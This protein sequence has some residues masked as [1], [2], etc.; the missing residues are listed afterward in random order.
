METS[1]SPSALCHNFY[2]INIHLGIWTQN[3]STSTWNQKD[4]SEMFWTHSK[5][6]LEKFDTQNTSRENKN[7][8]VHNLTSFCEWMT[9]LEGW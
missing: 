8:S 7:S 6:G 3:K 1:L 2:K 9:E 4:I 5:E